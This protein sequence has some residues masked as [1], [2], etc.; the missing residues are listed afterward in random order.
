[1][2]KITF[3]MNTFYKCFSLFTLICVSAGA[4]AQGESE[5][6]PRTIN[7]SHPACV[8][9]AGEYTGR[10]SV[11]VSSDI[12]NRMSRGATACTTINVNY[13]G[14]DAFP[15]AQA[16]FQYAVDIWAMSIESPQQITVSASFADL[17][18]GTLGSAGA[19]GYTTL[20]PAT[21]PGAIADTFYNISL[22]EKLSNSNI[23][24][25]FGIE[26]LAQFNNDTSEIPW[27]F[28]TDANPPSGQFD[29]VSVVLH[30]LGHGLGFAGFGSVDTQSGIGDIR[31]SGSGFASIYDTFIENGTANPILSFPDPSTELGSELTGNN[32]FCVGPIATGQN[33]NIAPRIFAPNSWN[34]G[35]SYSHWNES[36]FL[37]G[38]INSLMTPQIGPG[39]AN[40]N[41]GP[42]TLGFFE[43]MGWSICGGTLTVEDVSLANV[44]VGPNPFK[45]SISVQL[46]N[47]YADEYQ[48]DIIDINGRIITS[49][50]QEAKAGE[51]TI[52]NLDN[53][54]EALYFL[55]ITNTTNGQSITKKV[56]KI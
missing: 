52:S 46:S 53:L 45:S 36:T 17:S 4:Y 23:N 11:P 50:T 18:P 10:S 6:Q 7:P 14:F 24:G 42:I 31:D 20:N 44:V 26:I 38:D 32:L 37:A 56:V 29:F 22:A 2:N 51:L 48:L 41:P 55:K 27:Y 3:S 12:A 28:G 35:S 9:Y 43:D 8:Y 40:H 39:E 19:N 16:A 1:M 54:T 33:G 30:E 15:E 49:E 5:F 21:A 34:Q 13:S 25:T 47:A